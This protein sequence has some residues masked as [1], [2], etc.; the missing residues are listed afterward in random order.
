MFSIYLLQKR[1]RGAELLWIED[2]IDFILR[3]LKS[4]NVNNDIVFI[5]NEG[6]TS[7]KIKIY[8]VPIDAGDVVCRKF[9]D[10]NMELQ[11]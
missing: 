2:K 3:F 4:F 11:L 1:H 8:N 7:N 6:F 10:H 9:G 5:A